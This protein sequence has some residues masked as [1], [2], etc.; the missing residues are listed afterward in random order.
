MSVRSGLKD[1]PLRKGTPAW[2]ALV[3]RNQDRLAEAGS[4]VKTNS[5][6]EFGY[7]LLRLRDIWNRNRPYTRAV[8][9]PADAIDMAGRWLVAAARASGKM[10]E[11]AAVAAESLKTLSPRAARRAQDAFEAFGLQPWEIRGR[12]EPSV[13]DRLKAPFA[14]T[15]ADRIARDG[16]W[17][18]SI[19]PRRERT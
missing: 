2:P 4:V 11:T 3:L 18:P 6:N 19:Y 17:K 7:S 10:G 12:K 1:I 5:S 8:V 15:R 16:V 14:F 9:F 13:L